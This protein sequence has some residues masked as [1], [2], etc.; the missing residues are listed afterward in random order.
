VEDVEKNMCMGSILGN[1]FHLM[2]IIINAS[3]TN[4]QCDRG[5]AFTMSERSPLP[6]ALSS[7]GL[8]EGQTQVLNVSRI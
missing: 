2:L 7:M 6:P 4:S 3:W 8:S 1:Q 5:A